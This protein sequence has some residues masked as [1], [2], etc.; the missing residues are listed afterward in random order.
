MYKQNKI[1]GAQQPI[2]KKRKLGGKVRKGATLSITILRKQQIQSYHDCLKAFLFRHKIFCCNNNKYIDFFF[3]R[4]QSIELSQLPKIFKLSLA[5]FFSR[6]MRQELPEN[7]Q[8]AVPLFDGHILRLL[9]ASY[10][11]NA[12]KAKILWDLLQC[13][14]IAH[15]V[16][17]SMI[18]AAY[19]KHRSTLTAV[20][21]TPAKV[22]DLIRPYFREFAEE[23]KLH[24]TNETSLPPKSAYINC[25]R[26]SGGC[27]NWFSER[28]LLNSHGYE[29]RHNGIYR[30]DPVVFHLFGRPGVGKSFIQNHFA[31]LLSSRFGYQL[32]DIYYRSSATKHWDGYRGQLISEI[33]DIFMLMNDDDDITQIIQLCSN[34]DYVLP[35]ADLKEKGRKFV[36]EFLFLS[37]NAPHV[38]GGYNMPTVEALRRRIYP[39]YELLE[40]HNGFYRVQKHIKNGPNDA[41]ASKPGPILSFPNLR[42]LLEYFFDEMMVIYRQRCDIDFQCIPIVNQGFGMPGLALKF[43]KHAPENFPEVIACAIPEPLKVRMITKGSEYSWILKSAQKAMW[44]ALQKYPCFTLT[45]TPDIPIGILETWRQKKF[46]LSGDYDAATDN[47]NMDIMALAIDELCKVLPQHLAEW[48]RWEGGPHII[49]YPP[50]TNLAPV[51]QTKGQLMGSLLSFPILCV[52]NAATIGIV[53]HQDLENLEAMINGDDILFTENQRC[54]NQWKRISKS[55]GLVP[56]IGKNFQSLDW[57]S[58]NS[59]LLT[60]NQDMKFHHENTGS[61]GALSKVGSFLSNF[62]QA[63]K[64]APGDKSYF[65]KKAKSLLVKTPQSVDIPRAFGGLGISFDKDPSQLDKEIYFFF[66]MRKGLKKVTSHDDYSIWRVPKHLYKMY[67]NVLDSTKCR[68]VP[69]IDSEDVELIIFPWKE[70]REF[71]KWYKTVPYLR[72]RITKVVLQNEIPINTLKTVTVQIPNVNESFINNLKLRI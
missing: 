44:K 72:N 63:L 1:I 39:A 41:L 57:C 29:Y 32:A 22:L 68:E 37:T 10:K 8:S 65:I 66:L 11:R 4:F 47:M 6:E 25:T 62:E 35:M 33:D 54:I 36:S 31:T 46:L 59:Q 9:R 16:P 2:C 28:K 49:N 70:F 58:I 52:A 30:I 7:S 17:E 71:Q 48:L 14:D 40:R 69:A 45:G 23:V 60:R 20:G 43:P 19:E 12:C 21:V 55:M 34:C 5:T 50:K 42:L 61:F 18:A 67:Q 64:I 56:S 51:L 15:R 24:Y 13:K 53:K 3:E 38:A 27:L 26:S